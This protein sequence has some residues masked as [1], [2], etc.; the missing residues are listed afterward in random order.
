MNT[1][2]ERQVELGALDANILPT[3]LFDDR[4]VDGLGHHLGQSATGHLLADTLIQGVL[5]LTV[6]QVDQPDLDLTSAPIL[7]DGIQSNGRLLAPAEPHA[8]L[9]EAVF[10]SDVGLGNADLLVRK[11]HQR[12]SQQADPEGQQAAHVPIVFGRL[13][14]QTHAEGV[15]GKNREHGEK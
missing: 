15:N 5:I 7:L 11:Q 1:L 3:D 13:K 14:D 12:G 8:S 4:A 9:E 6:H 10:D 2:D